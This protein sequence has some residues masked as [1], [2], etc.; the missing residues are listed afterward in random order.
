MRDVRELPT[1]AFDLVTA[2]DA[3]HDQA[4]PAGVLRGAYEALIADGVFLMVDIN[5]SSN[6]EENVD[7]PMATFAYIASTMHCMQVS[8]AMDGAG[9]GTAW[10]HQLATSMLDDAGFTASRRTTAPPGDPF[11]LIYVARKAPTPG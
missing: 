1:D 8:L 10:G 4:D 3:I 2:F 5:A 11:N 6:L 7:N 9:L